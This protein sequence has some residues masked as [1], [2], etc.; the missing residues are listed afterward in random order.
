MPTPEQSIPMFAAG[1]FVA[2]LTATTDA[3]KMNRPR[4]N[5]MIIC[6]HNLAAKHY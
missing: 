1:G 5:I 2:K 6:S 4:Q 3:M